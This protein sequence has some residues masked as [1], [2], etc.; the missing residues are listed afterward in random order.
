MFNSFGQWKKYKDKV[1]SS[2]KIECGIR[3]NP[4]YSEIST[5][6]IIPA[7]KLKAWVTLANFR[8]MDGI[9]GLHFHTMCEQNSDTL[10]EPSVLLMKVREYIKR[11]KWVNLGGGHHITRPDYDIETLVSSILYFKEKYGVD[12][13]LEPGEL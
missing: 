8:P 7:I 2:S 4:E 13:Y 6:S 11:M 5:Q 3:I 1:K 12:I 10:P 9:D